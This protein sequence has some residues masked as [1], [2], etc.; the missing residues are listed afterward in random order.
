[1]KRTINL[2]AIAVLLL[3][4]FSCTKIK[5]EDMTVIKDC[6][7]VYLRFNNRD[8][9]VCNTEKV[10]SFENNAEVKATFKKINTCTGTASEATVCHMLH[11]NEGWIEVEKIE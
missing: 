1:M 2:I 4:I 3:S 8:Y 10:S 5:N 7:G 11:E 9:H 6:T